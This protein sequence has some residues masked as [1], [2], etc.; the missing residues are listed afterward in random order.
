MIKQTKLYFAAAVV[1]AMGISSMASAH[2]RFVLPSHT[3]LSSESTQFVTLTSSISNDIFHPDRP[4]GNNEKG[5]DSGE[6]APLF[7]VLQT[8]VTSPD[9][10]LTD[11]IQWQAFHRLSVADVELQKTGTYRIAIVQPDIAMTTYKD[12]KQAYQRKFGKNPTLPSDAT[13]IVRRTTASSVATYISLNQPSKLAPTGSGL[14]LSGDTHPNDLFVAESASFQLLFDGKPSDEN[15]LVKVIKGGTR[16]RNY[17][18]ETIVQL[19][20]EGRFEWTPAESGFYLLVAE[21]EVKVQQPAE[22][23]VKHFSLNLTLEVFAE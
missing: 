12:A 1:A 9:G 3:V 11:S 19:D 21:K 17:R 22:V 7:N 4:L 18:A 14:E 20:K 8:K 2:E 23:D 5:I 15:T 6:L 10:Q 13:D 16:H